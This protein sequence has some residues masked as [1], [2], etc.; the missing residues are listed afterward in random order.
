[1]P[2]KE[3]LTVKEQIAYMRDHCGIKFE[4]CSEAEAEQFLRESTYFFKAKAFAKDFQKEKDSEKYHDLDF[5]YLKELSTLDAFLRKQIVALTQDIEHFLKVGLMADISQNPKEDGYSLMAQYFAEYPSVKTDIVNKGKVSYCKDLV[6]K[7]EQ[8]GY[9]V[10]NA[11]EVLSFGQ[12]INLYRLYSKNNGGWNS[13]LCNLLLPTKWL[14]NAAAHNN[15]LLNSLQR[16]YS[17]TFR[18]SNQVDSYVSQIPSLKRSKSKVSKLSNPVIHD[19]VAS[20]F[21]FDKTGTSLKTRQYT[22]RKL[23]K[24][25]DTMLPR[26]KDY[27]L[28]NATLVSSYKFAK[29]IVDFLY[30]KAYTGYV[31]QKL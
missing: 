30:E 14:R 1:M 10:W 17:R 5:A 28:A 13:K 8:E 4:I 3:K 19:F 11:I 23:K 18:V 25:F 15:C 26:N 9:A 27:F 24:F 31:E 21:L 22:Y 20:L 16:P 6:G 7:M 12:F 2:R 29:K